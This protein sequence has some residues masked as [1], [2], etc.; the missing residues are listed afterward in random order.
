MKIIKKLQC[1]VAS[2][3]GCLHKGQKRHCHVTFHVTGNIILHAPLS[4]VNWI[5]QG[6]LQWQPVPWILVWWSYSTTSRK[7]RMH[8]HSP[9]MW[10]KSWKDFHQ[11]TKKH[12]LR[13]DI[14]CSI[15]AFILK[16]NPFSKESNFFKCNHNVHKCLN[17]GEEAVYTG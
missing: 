12:S 13:Y 11:W 6:P 10:L 8:W 5:L 7:R 4:G 2:W 17:R 15:R 9:K 1:V 14:K 3:N 16:A